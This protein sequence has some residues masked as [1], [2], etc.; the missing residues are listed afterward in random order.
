MS[1]ITREQVL[2][3]LKKI[4]SDVNCTAIIKKD[5]IN[6]VFEEDYPKHVMEKIQLELKKIYQNCLINIIHT[7]DK[8]E[9][10]MQ[11]TKSEKYQLPNVKKI[12]LVSSCKGGVGKSTMTSCI[13]GSLV[14]EGLKVG[15]VDADI[16]GPSIPTL[17]GTE[18]KID[19]SENKFIPKEKGGIKIISM[20]NLVDPE[21]AAVWRGP[22]VSKMLYQLIMG[23]NWGELDILL[24]DTPPGTGDVALSLMEKY[25]VDGAILVTTPHLLAVNE[26]VK[27][28]DMFFKLNI[29]ILGAIENMSYFKD[30]TGEIYYIY[31]KSNLEKI[32]NDHYISFL[33]EVPIDSD[34]AKGYSLDSFPSLYRRIIEKLL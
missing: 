16:Y 1:N 23:T 27:S 31:G 28:I 17:F 30:N 9:L 24:V 18:G 8:K 11:S 22:M 29:P 33:G 5:S 21:K 4:K 26:I 14:K 25:P 13:A 2:F 34:F 3:S 7:S 20:G 15:I 32:L 19:I 10:P 6:L 12:I